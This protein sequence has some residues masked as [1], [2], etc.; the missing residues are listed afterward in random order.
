MRIN[1]ITNNEKDN[2]GM[3]AYTTGHIRLFEMKIW[4]IKEVSQFTG[5]AVSSLYNMKDLPRRKRRGR[6][7]FY[8]DEIVNWIDTGGLDDD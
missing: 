4:T 8:P 7:F 3:N 6:L 1:N 5:F 2:S